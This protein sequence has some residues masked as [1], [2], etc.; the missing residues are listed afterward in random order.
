MQLDCSLSVVSDYCSGAFDL[1]TADRWARNGYR[2]SCRTLSNI[3]GTNA[4]SYYSR[5]HDLTAVR[6]IGH[7]KA[8]HP[9]TTYPDYQAL[10][11]RT[12]SGENG[13]LSSLPVQSFLI[14]AGTTG[15]PKLIPQVQN[16]YR[17]FSPY[18]IVQHIKYA[19][20]LWLYAIPPGIGRRCLP[21]TQG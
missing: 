18:R 7:L 19:L 4:S 16:K 6:T 17:S 14:T 12:A 15:E 13:L 8:A 10:I 3:L 9:L 5:A 2:N 11:N 20:P 21:L 1:R